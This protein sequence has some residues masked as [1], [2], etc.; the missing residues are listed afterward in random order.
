MSVHLSVTRCYSVETAKHIIIL[1]SPSGSH[2][3]LVFPYHMVWHMV[4]TCM[5]NLEMSGILTAVR[6]MSGILLK[7]RKVSG[8][9]LLKLFIVSCIF[10]SIP[11]FSSTSM[12]SMIWVTLNMGKSA[13]SHQWI[14]G[15][16]HIIWK[17]VTLM[18][19]LD[20]DSPNGGVE[21]SGYEKI[22]IFL[23]VS[24]FISEIMQD[25]AI[26]TMECE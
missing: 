16:F 19:I 14:V 1:F 15:E 8:K 21:C 9:K 20:R 25:K 18:A 3:I 23:P 17:V 11:V 6:E 5:E 12:S 22:A 7:V 24:C 13:A 10:A 26:I 4:T 2:T